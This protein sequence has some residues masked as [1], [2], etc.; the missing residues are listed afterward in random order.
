[1][2]PWNCGAT[3]IKGYTAE[4]IIGKKIVVFYPK[5][6][7]KKQKIQK[8]LEM[9]IEYELFECEGWRLRKDGTA[10]WANIIFTALKAETGK[11]YGFLK[12]ARD[13][14]ERKKSLDVLNQLN[15]A[16]E[17]RV[18]EST[19]MLTISEAFNKGVLN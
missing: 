3:K 14:L 12:I 8:N 6:D 5:K 19:A 16:L 17:K 1:M 4:E 10:F 18:I 13:I 7:I 9:V 15:S 2:A 11:L